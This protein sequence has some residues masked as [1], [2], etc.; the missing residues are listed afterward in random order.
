ME[1]SSG[2]TSL[3][4]IATRRHDQLQ[5][6]TD[7]DH[8]QYAMT[9][10]TLAARPAAGTALRLYYATDTG[11]IYR[12]NGVSWDNVSD[13]QYRQLGT[14]TLGAPNVAL[15]QAIAS[16]KFLR[17]VVRMAGFSAGSQA[18]IRFN[19]DAGNNY[20]MSYSD[21]FAAGTNLANY[22][23]GLL[24][25]NAASN[26]N[27]FI[28][29]IFNVAGQNKHW[30]CLGSGISGNTHASCGIWANAVDAITSIS[31]IAD[32]VITVSTGSEIT[33]FG[34]D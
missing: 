33:V 2:V 3:G 8:P 34:H 31:F 7:N 25:Q 4:D 29:D 15:T 11:I 6:L 17:V 22:S 9:Y 24:M 14:T 32:G 23:R 20:S 1:I 21:Q 5:E 30:T 12:D 10:G 27:L 18:A 19:A 16:R 26:E 13:D 28:I